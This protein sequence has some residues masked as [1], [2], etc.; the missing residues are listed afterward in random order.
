MSYKQKIFIIG[1]PHGSFI[2]F[3]DIDKYVK[4]NYQKLEEPPIIIVLGDFGGNF[5]FTDRDDKFKAKL[6]KYNLQYFIIRGNHEERPSNLIKNNPEKWHTALFF[7]NLVYIEKKY[8]YIKYAIDEPS[9]YQI[10]I[11]KS[12][13]IKTLVLPGAYSV[14][15]QYRLKRG[16]SWF[17][18]EQPTE[19]EKQ[20][21][22]NLV[23]NNK[24]INL[25]LSH[26]CPI[27]YEPTDLFLPQVDQSTVDSS[28]EEWLEQI[29]KN[30]KPKL[31]AW[32]HFHANR[33]YKNYNK[34]MLFNNAIF[35]LKKYFF[36]NS[37]QQSVIPLLSTANI[38]IF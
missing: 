25:I 36:N 34:I 20:I 33:I 11:A 12:K 22:I 16:W 27:S 9:I 14:D 24:D 8:P 15:K 30:I 5:F 13:T 18:D 3:R 4:N 38:Q 1:D 37:L 29:N 31:W 6:G 2:P 7:H 32:G 21:G 19:I 10:P 26:T 28:T 17:K 23:K 35:D